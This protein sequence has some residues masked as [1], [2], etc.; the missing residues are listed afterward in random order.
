MMERGNRAPVADTI[1]AFSVECSMG[2]KSDRNS[3]FSFGGFSYCKPSSVP[4]LCR[5]TL[6]NIAPDEIHT[7]LH[8]IRL[9]ATD[10]LQ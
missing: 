2:I 10:S 4:Y 7:N 9:L 1:P 8:E 5:H 3:C 6:C